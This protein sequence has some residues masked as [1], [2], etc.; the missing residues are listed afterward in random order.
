MAATVII[1]ARSS[2]E[3]CKKK[4]VGL[5]QLPPHVPELGLAAGGGGARVRGHRYGLGELLA[6]P[7][8]EG[9]APLPSQCP[10]PPSLSSGLP[11]EDQFCKNVGKLQL[12]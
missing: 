3:S 12:Q 7:G 2:E 8:G 11:L 9:T 5:P 4:K 10:S 1:S 6:E